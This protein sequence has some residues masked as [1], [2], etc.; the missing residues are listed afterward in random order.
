MVSV[1]HFDF[2]TSEHFLELALNQNDSGSRKINEVHL[3]HTYRPDIRQYESGAGDGDINGERTG[4]ALCEG[5]WRYHTQTLNWQDIAQ[6]VTIDPQGR[7]WL[8]RDWNLPPA[9]ASGFNGNKQLGPF[10]IEV[11][12]NFDAGEETLEGA[13]RDAVCTVIAA[14]QKAFDLPLEALRFHNEMSQKSCPGDTASKAM[15]LE[16]VKAAAAILD[17]VA[18]DRGSGTKKRAPLAD[19]QRRAVRLMKAMRDRTSDRETKR[20]Y[21][22]LGDEIDCAQREAAV[23]TIRATTRGGGGS[24]TMTA[25][26]FSRLRDHVVHLEQGSFVETGPFATPASNLNQIITSIEAWADTLPNKVPPRI[27]IHAHGGLNDTEMAL[28]Y[29]SAMRDWWKEN[30]V[31]PIFFVWETG[32]LETVMQLLARVTGFTPQDRGLFD[33]WRE[34]DD[35]AVEALVRTVGYPFWNTMKVSAE[36]AARALDS[37]GAYA[38]AQALKPLFGAKSRY[39]LHAVGHSAGAIFH[40]YFMRELSERK[41][42]VNSLTYLAPA[43]TIELFEAEVKGL[44]G[45][46]ARKNIGRFR[47]F[48]LDQ[49]HEI[50]DPTVPI[51]DS[52]LL[53]LV[54]RGFEHRE[55]SSILGL[56]ESIRRDGAMR[57]FFGLD[58]SEALGEIIWS[59]TQEDASPAARSGAKVHGG[60]ASDAQTMKSVMAEILGG[61]DPESLSKFPFS[62]EER[63]GGKPLFRSLEDSLPFAL[64][65]PSSTVASPAIAAQQVAKDSGGA[66]PAFQPSQGRRLALSIGIN[67]YPTPYKLNGCEE[68]TKLWTDT[69]DNLG[70]EIRPPLTKDATK[71]KIQS[72]IVDLV[73]TSEPGDVL[74]MHFSGHGTYF[75][76]LDGDET[77]DNLDEAWVPIDAFDTNDYIIDDDIRSWLGRLKPGVDCTLFIDC[78][79][80]GS[81]SRFAIGSG[82]RS[83]DGFRERY[84]APTRKMRERYVAQRMARGIGRSAPE[85]GEEQMN[86]IVF[87]ACKPIQTAKESGG[88]G[89]FSKAATDV[90]RSPADI[91]T[92]GDLFRQIDRLFAKRR[93]HRNDQHPQ[94]EGK[95]IWKTRPIF[96]GIML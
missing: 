19:D 63:N 77:D 61:V 68:D 28:A 49:A 14:M 43:C 16:D 89:W 87:S 76:D 30:G 5:M 11:I 1:P 44:I 64:P 22:S 23:R 37:R 27:M 94:L 21:K 48:N 20:S 54:E 56:E 33:G 53:Y 72:A 83:Q 82:A 31:Y 65:R 36:R 95:A 26:E 52:S 81:S 18:S 9:S 86:H 92:N 4:R 67:D 79:H 8:C 25:D 69:F 35:R 84:I 71:N 7:I 3:H 6:H 73:E 13:Q 38:L 32:I 58:G 74:A 78:C 15:I 60:F 59:P 55:R 93:H 29:A 50:A 91:K 62:R 10:M 88:H 90:L 80:S 70:F 24:G 51:Y 85:G 41:V 45:E 96:G 39:E 17:P 47:Q 40:S 75:D 34:W 57:G 12:G 46:G 66:M 2:V 42:P